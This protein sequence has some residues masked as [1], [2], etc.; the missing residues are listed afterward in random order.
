MRI[1]LALGT[2]L[3]LG[4]IDS[5]RISDIDFENNSITTRSKKAGKD[6]HES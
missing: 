4:D 3:R 6:I 1:L 2:G 5:I